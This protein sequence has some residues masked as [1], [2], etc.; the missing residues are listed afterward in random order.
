MRLPRILV[1][2]HRIACRRPAAHHDSEVLPARKV[3]RAIA[4]DARVPAPRAV[5]LCLRR[6]ALPTAV[7]GP[8]RV[9]VAA[10]SLWAAALVVD[11]HVPMPVTRPVVVHEDGTGGQAT[12]RGVAWRLEVGER[13]PRRWQPSR[14]EAVLLP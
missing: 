5:V 4:E 2:T 10:Q 8:G 7:R 13:S 9:W 11:I 14:I 6:A 12:P 3:A 1:L